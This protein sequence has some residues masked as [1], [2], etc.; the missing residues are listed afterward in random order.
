M[1]ALTPNTPPAPLTVPTAVFVLLHTPAPPTAVASLKVIVEPVHTEVAPKI[2]PATGDMFT[3]TTDVAVT[4]PQD[5]V[6]I[7]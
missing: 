3:V 2:A 4:V 7:V 6:A 1:P 5:A